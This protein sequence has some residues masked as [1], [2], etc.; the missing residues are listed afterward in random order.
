MSRWNHDAEAL[1][2]MLPW[3]RSRGYQVVDLLSE[4]SQYGHD[5][6][7]SAQPGRYASL[8]TSFTEHPKHLP[9]GA[10][11]LFLYTAGTPPSAP[12]AAHWLDPF[13]TTGAAPFSSLVVT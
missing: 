2:V 7:S 10:V 8:A 9:I 3:L 11:L 13:R 6:H 12:T 1:A 4:K 5:A